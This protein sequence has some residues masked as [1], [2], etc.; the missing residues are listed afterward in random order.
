MKRIN[1]WLVNFKWEFM[2]LNKKQKC[3]QTY[4]QAVRQGKA[5]PCLYS[6][7][8]DGRWTFL[9]IYV[10]D[11]IVCHENPKDYQAHTLTK[12]GTMLTFN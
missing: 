2:G 8:E 11:L 12:Q 3:G 10:D 7:H 5:D 9:L 1:I 4:C 6:R